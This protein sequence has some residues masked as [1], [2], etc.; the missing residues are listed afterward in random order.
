MAPPFAF[1]SAGLRSAEPP[2]LLGQHT[3]E[4]L[5]ELGID[6]ERLAAL[7]E[8]GVVATAET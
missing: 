8:R 1:E 7:V 6:V 2:P 5:T 3:Q 4:V